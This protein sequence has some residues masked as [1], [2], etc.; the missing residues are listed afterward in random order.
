MMAG[1]EL[2]APDPIDPALA[3]L[4]EDGALHVALEPREDGRSFSAT[5]V[6]PDERGV[7]SDEAGVLSL[8][9]LRVLSASIGSHA[10][11]TVNSFVVAPRFGS[12]PEAALLRQEL[13]RA[14]SGDL[15]L[16]GALEA[17]DRAERESRLP[18][19]TARAVPV[20]AALAPPRIIWF[21]GSESDQVVLEIRSEDRIGLLCRL[22][23]VFE[24]VGADVRWARV[25]TLGS[26]VIDSFCVDLAGA[27]TRVSRE[28]L[29]KE[30]LSVL[31][32]PEP[33]APVDGA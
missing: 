27:H 3:N 16:L 30:L 14:R 11:S 25:S 18:E 29:E 7:L 22:A 6:A 26:T 32:A 23:D 13:V 9:G 1:D 21:E 12:P 5:F 31:P 28:H 17:K 2:P 8:H 15:D 19:R 10:G 33:P 4:A 20:S 24:R